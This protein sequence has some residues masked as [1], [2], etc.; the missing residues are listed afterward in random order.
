M[1]LL[2]LS[3]GDSFLSQVV[4]G[5]IVL[6]L[7]RLLSF[8]FWGSPGLPEH[9][10]LCSTFLPLAVPLLLC[11]RWVRGQGGLHSRA[12]GGVSILS[13]GVGCRN[14]EIFSMLLPG[15]VSLERVVQ[16]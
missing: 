7:H 4:M 16:I 11:L 9:V 1:G 8:W 14:L 3:F 2:F 15:V 6:C 5:C 10:L 13:P 12:G